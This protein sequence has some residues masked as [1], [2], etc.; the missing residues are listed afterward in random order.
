MLLNWDGSGIARSR[1]PTDAARARTCLGESSSSRGFPQQNSAANQPPPP[2]FLSSRRAPPR[3]GVRSR[4]NPIGPLE[5]LRLIIPPVLGPLQAA[6]PGDLRHDARVV[7]AAAAGRGRRR[8]VLRPSRPRPDPGRRARRA[9]AVGDG[10]V[11]RHASSRRGVRGVDVERAIRARRRRGRVGHRARAT[12]EASR[13][14]RPGMARR[15]SVSRASRPRLWRRRSSSWGDR[16]CNLC[17]CYFKS[18]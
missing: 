9:A 16:D 2:L 17:V 18:P 10:I 1:P 12:P 7:A 13:G 14:R 5:R 6:G 11:V 15:V 8:V 3:G 4:L